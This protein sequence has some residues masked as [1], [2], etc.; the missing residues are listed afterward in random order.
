MIEVIK[1]INTQFPNRTEKI[2][3]SIFGRTSSYYSDEPKVIFIE[4]NT[5]DHLDWIEE[6][7][8]TS[9]PTTL[10]YK[11]GELIAEKKGIIASQHIIA[12]IEPYIPKF[13]IKK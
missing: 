10:F 2:Y 1:V 9:F 6:N 11:D 4:K 8:I 12:E 7:N 3:S 13:A 5:I